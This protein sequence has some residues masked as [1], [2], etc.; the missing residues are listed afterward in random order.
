MIVVRVLVFWCVYYG[1]GEGVV[2]MVM[3]WYD[4]GANALLWFL[5]WWCSRYVVTV[6]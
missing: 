2:G 6:W 1:Y 4:G 5:W 3:L